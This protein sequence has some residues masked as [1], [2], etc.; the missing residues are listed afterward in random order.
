MVARSFQRPCEISWKAL[1]L[2]DDAELAAETQWARSRPTSCARLQVRPSELGL[3]LPENE[4]VLALTV[5]EVQ[6]LQ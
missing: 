1:L 6:R 2:A 5:S 4:F 3:K